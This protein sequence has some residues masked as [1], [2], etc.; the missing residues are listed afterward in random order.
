MLGQIGQRPIA[1]P[2]TGPRVATAVVARLSAGAV[3][4]A[5]GIGKFASHSSEVDS[6]RSYGLP[7]ADTF[8]FAIGAVEVVGGLLLIAGLATRLAAAV[9]AGN[10]IGAIVVSGILQGEALSLTLAPAL[11]AATLYLLWIGPG[12]FSLDR[13]LACRRRRPGGTTQP[14]PPTPDR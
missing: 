4:V 8:V 5:F 12:C 7:A 14:R 13:R 10:M 9:L 1:G 2:V 6:F 3:F 11:L